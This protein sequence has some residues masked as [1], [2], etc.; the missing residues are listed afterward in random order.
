MNK[1]SA[2]DVEANDQVF[3]FVFLLLPLTLSRSEELVP[4]CRVA[5]IRTTNRLISLQQTGQR[6][7]TR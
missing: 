7:L 6:T 2:K 4:T 3:F 1:R 5:T